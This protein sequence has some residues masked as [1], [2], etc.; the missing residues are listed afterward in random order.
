MKNGRHHECFLVNK[1]PP[2]Q[3][4]LQPV[5]ISLLAMNFMTLTLTTALHGC[6]DQAIDILERLPQHGIS[7]SGGLCTGLV[8]EKKWKF[9]EHTKGEG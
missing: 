1:Y 2:C 8:K 9:P 4:G 7:F 5:G 6:F 3:Q